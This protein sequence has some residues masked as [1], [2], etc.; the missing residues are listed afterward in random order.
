MARLAD[1]HA[2]GAETVIFTP[3]C[4]PERH[5]EVTALFAQEVLPRLPGHDRAGS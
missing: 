1:Y 2:A 3:A 5:D 4:A